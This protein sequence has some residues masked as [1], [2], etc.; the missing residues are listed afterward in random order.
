MYHSYR[1]PKHTIRLK[2]GTGLAVIGGE[3]A[4]GPKNYSWLQKSFLQNKTKTPNDGYGGGIRINGVTPRQGS[5]HL[6][7]TT[8]WKKKLLFHH[9]RAKP[10][11][12]QGE[13]EAKGLGHLKQSSSKK[14]NY[15]IRQEYGF[16]FP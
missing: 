11:G 8:L 9:T 16:F 10:K 12:G 14:P 2:T 7:L 5:R 1:E 15:I 4:T 13:Y 6:G 3:R